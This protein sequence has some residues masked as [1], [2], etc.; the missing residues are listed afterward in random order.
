MFVWHYKLSG[1]IKI[2]QRPRLIIADKMVCIPGWAG[3][4]PTE[5]ELQSDM[6]STINHGE[7]WAKSEEAVLIGTFTK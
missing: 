1:N 5:N 4:I 7:I 6:E 3:A 2:Y